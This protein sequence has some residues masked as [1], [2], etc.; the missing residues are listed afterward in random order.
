MAI[1]SN[2]T[3]K[4]IGDRNRS[5]SR[6]L[7]FLL[8]CVSVLLIGL[9]EIGSY[10]YARQSTKSQITHQLEEY[11]RAQAV[12]LN[13]LAATNQNDLKRLVK[14]GSVLQ[15]IQTLVY[16]PGNADKQKS[17]ISALTHYRLSTLSEYGEQVYIFSKE[18]L[19][20]ASTNP[21]IQSGNYRNH[22][23]LSQLIDTG[24]SLAAYNPSP[25]ASDRLVILSSLMINDSHGNQVASLV[26]T[27]ISP[28]PASLLKSAG[29]LASGTQ[30]QILLP[31]GTMIAYQSEQNRWKVVDT[32]PA[33]V[34]Q[35]TN[36]LSKSKDSSGKAEQFTSI[37]GQKVL[38]VVQNV[39]DLKISLIVEIPR[40]YGYQSFPLINP[41][42]LI[43]FFSAVLV[44]AGL[45]RLSL[46]FTIRPI[47]QLASS[48]QAGN[49][50]SRDL[51]SWIERK[52][53]I[54]ILARSFL[55]LSQ[56]VTD[57]NTQ[58]DDRV[59]QRTRQ[60]RLAAE[61]AQ[62][63]TSTNDKTEMAQRTVQQ[64]VERF[65]YLYAGIY[66]LD[67]AN[68]QAV[69]RA[70]RS[71][72]GDT[73]SL[74]GTKVRTGAQSL[75]GWVLAN[76]Q[77]RRMENPIG[78]SH[79]QENFV[80]GAYSQVVIP[81]SM[82]DIIYG[83]LV[84]QSD[85]PN[86]FDQDAI[87]MLRVVTNQVAA[88]LQNIRTLETAQI[89]LEETALL[90]RDTQKIAQAGSENDLLD[91]L[92]ST[93][94]L[95]PF[96]N[97]IYTVEKSRIRAVAIQDPD[98]LNNPTSFPGI[99]LP[100]QEIEIHLTRNSPV[101]INRISTPNDFASLLTPFLRYGCLSAAVFP[102]YDGDSLSKIVVLAAR[103]N[104][105][106]TENSIRPY[107]NFF[108]V[109]AS[110]LSRLNILEN[111][112]K[113]LLQLQALNQISQTVS[114]EV[115]LQKIYSTLHE[116]VLKVIGRDVEFAVTIYNPRRNMIEIP[117]MSEGSVIRTIEPFPLG[118][119]LTSHVLTSRKTLMINTNTR[120][121][122]EQLGAKVV[123]Q[124]ARSW[125]G[126]PLNIGGEVIGALILQDLEQENR[127]SDEDA[128]LI[129]TVATQVAVTIR[130]AQ[131]F[132]EM[133]KTEGLAQ[134]NAQQI[135]T[136]AEV[137]RDASRSLEI[138]EVLSRA[139]NLIHDRFG[140]YHSSIFL[141]DPSSNFAVLRESTGDA[142]QQMKAM[143]HR[144][145]VGSKSIVGQATSRG[146]TL[147]V[148][149]VTQDPIYYANPLMPDTRSELAIPLKIGS[150]VLGALD[151]QST[152]LNA[153]SD[154]DVSIL[155]LLAD[156]L[157]VSVY[158]ARLFAAAQQ[159]L[160]RH[161]LIHE[162]TTAATSKTT[163]DEVLRTTTA[164]LA[165]AFPNNRVGLYLMNER[166][167]LEVRTSAGYASAGPSTQNIHSGDGPIGTAA[168]SRR[169]ILVKDANL[170]SRFQPAGEDIR[171]Q[172]AAPILYS[173][174]S[175]GVLSIEAPLPNAF[176]DNDLE[177]LGTLGN[178]LGAVL[179]NAQLIA[180]VRRQVERQRMIYD[181]ASRIRRSV[182]IET[183][184]KTSAAEIGQALGAN[185]V[186]IEI[187]PSD[188]SSYPT[189]GLPPQSTETEERA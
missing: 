57:L 97:G 158:N 14:D 133:Q 49:E 66:T 175:M 10:L 136:A 171:S 75:V 77:A 81:I 182:D 23:I 165:Q 84:V 188:V 149:D 36:F 54:G 177:I 103:E 173:G 43:I 152:Q 134:K 154:E 88:G 47:R 12:Q 89:D 137:A 16:D 118:E 95:C 143:N 52:D 115:D 166:N 94:K 71:Q 112:S 27:M 141:V 109:T 106:I 26:G 65:G 155:Q 105:R 111:L 181:A 55:R 135:R 169:A 32:S 157:A 63:V 76:N 148:N 102:L 45:L 117:Y 53:E 127:F 178:S 144:L 15:A 31:S 42:M 24:T 48:V 174:K 96:V 116:Q 22:P 70:E 92:K 21:S 78:E 129:E 138:T 2:A 60:I 180:E 170:D 142:G 30:A 28:L 120:Q 126:V 11:T 147:V 68:T 113:T 125:L 38:G 46:H 4:K 17:A 156:Q 41:V 50:G 19:L 176:D 164:G 33:Y 13:D 3:T 128:Q 51:W 35:I 163:T 79:P 40:G 9:A 146:D 34:Q 114:M 119:G 39:P 186:R 59:E 160:T 140:F 1:P 91:L 72:K 161:R 25:F 162:I 132:A 101:V 20:L 189:P 107:A 93:L 56:Q 29:N 87:S 122:S 44:C 187:G 73:A 98:A 85:L 80:P 167:I 8:L 183:I 61:V 131:L 18:G 64:I 74:L 124:P 172:L 69:L 67:H 159:N 184:L 5:I 145:A 153:F 151:V 82:G 86:V 110:T 168:E 121:R 108:A 179:Y 37:D 7:F 150:S 83:V 104:Q 123:G 185:R 6:G 139:V 130:N 90:Y 62:A 99:D 58:M 100:Y